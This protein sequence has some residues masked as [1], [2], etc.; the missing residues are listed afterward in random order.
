MCLLDAQ[1]AEESSAMQKGIVC[2]R[3]GKWYS[4]GNRSAVEHG[5]KSLFAMGQISYV[6]AKGMIFKNPVCLTPIKSLVF[7]CYDEHSL[8]L[9]NGQRRSFF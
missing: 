1:G 8:D 5:C 6:V 4:Y 7:E 3:T 9:W 2:W